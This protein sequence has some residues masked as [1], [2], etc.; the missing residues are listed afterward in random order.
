M[1]S[2]NVEINVVYFLTLFKKFLNVFNKSFSQFFFIAKHLI[3]S[4]SI[5]PSKYTSW[6]ELATLTLLLS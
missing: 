1:T 3:K 5:N 2:E 4:S 6:K